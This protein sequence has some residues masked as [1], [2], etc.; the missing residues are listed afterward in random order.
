MS[1]LSAQIRCLFLFLWIL[2]AC[3]T[4][5]QA[6]TPPTGIPTLT[7]I[8]SSAPTESPTYETPD[9]G[10]QAL[11][12]GLERRMIRLFDDQNQHIESLYIFRLDQNYFRLDVAYHETPLNVE[13]WQEQTNALMVVNGGFYRE[14]N[15]K[16]VPNGLTIING[17]AFGSSYEGFG[18]MLALSDGWAELRSL[19]QQPYYV[20][21]PLQ[22][23][24]QSFP[25][26]VKPG[27]ELGFPAESEDNVKARRTVI[28]QDREGRI[29][30]I[31][32]PRGDFTLHQLSLYVTRS[33][34]NLD[35]AINLDGG[36]STGIL[37]AEPR[38]I[39]PSQTLLPIVILVY[40][41]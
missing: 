34:L 5:P 19:A 1:K 3:A 26:L 6:V 22:A 28:A 10:W 33:D 23:A 39:I 41:R 24:L 9:T 15:E 35:I 37:L 27:G 31:L 36:P 30:F 13:D 18:G 2:I 25:M 14:E 21:E 32:A 12:L 4:V 17:Q 38:E 20:G 7:L 29:L 8:P 16:P 11:Q 40:P